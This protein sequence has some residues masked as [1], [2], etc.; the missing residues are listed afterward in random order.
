VSAHD[1]ARQFASL[2]TTYLVVCGI[3]VAVVFAVVLAVLVRYRAAAGREPASPRERHLLLGGYAL[4]LLVIAVFLISATFSKEHGIDSSSTP[5][6]ATVT[7]VAS[8]WRWTFGYPGHPGA[9]SVDRLVVPQNEV[10]R[11]RMRS[12]DV[13]HSIWFVHERFKR[14][15]I[16]GSPT[17]FELTFA[18]AGVFRGECAQFCGLGHDDMRFTVHVVSPAVYTRW[19]AGR[20]AA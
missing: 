3:A 5:A 6:A 16:P 14:Y 8:Q 11:F 4:V 12:A 19:L 1:T 17:Q 15:A 20:S 2:F 7:V 10:V 18:T 13:I 9:T